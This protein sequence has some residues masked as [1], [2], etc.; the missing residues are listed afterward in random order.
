MNE[1]KSTKYLMGALAVLAIVALVVWMRT[2]GGTAP[3]PTGG[4]IYY[5]G[6]M[7]KKGDAKPFK[8]A[9][10]NGAQPRPRTQGGS[11][12]G[13]GPSSDGI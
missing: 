13:P 5:T 7:E 1:G 12:M 6:P 10:P 3:Q 9:Q 11:Q 2:S 4:A 8:G